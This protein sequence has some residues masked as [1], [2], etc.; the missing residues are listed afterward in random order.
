MNNMQAQR[1]F[2]LYSIVLLCFM[3]DFPSYIDSFRELVTLH[4]TSS[5]F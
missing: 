3:V 4:F 2:K 1:S 5:F